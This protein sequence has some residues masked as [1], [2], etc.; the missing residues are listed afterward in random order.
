ML[1]WRSLKFNF[2][3]S[4]IGCVV[5]INTYSLFFSVVT[6]V[7]LKPGLLPELTTNSVKSARD[8][9][10]H[11]LHLV[12]SPMN[13]FIKTVEWGHS[14]CLNVFV[15]NRKTKAAKNSFRLWKTVMIKQETSWLL[16]SIN[17]FFKYTFFTCKLVQSVSVWEMKEMKGIGP[18]LYCL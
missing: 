2:S 18:L 6:S 3:L 14:V 12:N 1:Q 16:F 4:I 10:V 13:I 7:F 15:D 8:Y 5:Y 9:F 17:L 11:V